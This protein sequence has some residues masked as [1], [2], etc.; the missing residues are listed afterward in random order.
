LR[1]KAVAWLAGFLACAASVLVVSAPRAA[2][3]SERLEFRNS[4]VSGSITDRKLHQPITLPAGSTLSATGE[5]DRQTGKGTLAANVLVP[6][7]SA[8]LR[9]FGVLPVTLAMTLT[10][11]GS[12]QGEL[13]PGETSGQE[14]LTLPLKLVV[15]VSSLSV[16]GMSIPTECTSTQP[17]AL[18]LAETLSREELLGQ[19]WHFSGTATLPS[20]GCEGPFPGRLLGFVFNY[21]ISGPENPYSVT[22]TPAV[23]STTS[24]TTT[25]AATTATSTTATTTQTTST[26]TSTT[27]TGGPEVVYVA[28]ADSGPVD[29]YRASSSGA[30]TPVVE[31]A[32]PQDPSTFWDPWGV[33]LDRAGDIY[34]QSFL[35]DATTFVFAPHSAPGAL[36]SRIFRV[37]GPDSR[38]IAVDQEG[39]EYVPSGE[40][41]SVIAVAA[42]G[43]AGAA[44]AGLYSVEPVRTFATG[45][46]IFSPW[47]DILTTSGHELLFASAKGEGNAVETFAGGPS[48]SA[49]PLRVL[50]GSATGLGTCSSPCDHVAVG[51]SGGNLYA[52]VSGGAAESHV[53]VFSSS[54]SGNS[55]P[56]RTI[57]GSA[58]GL[59]GKVITGIAASPATGELYVMVKAAEFEASGQIEVF[60]P[61]ASGNVAPLRTFTDAARAFTDAMGI[62]IGPE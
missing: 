25:T 45:E 13:A 42:P 7:F 46:G 36:P 60:A 54:A 59:D 27:G 49:T 39:Y 15:R 35:S 48:G 31:L 2:A 51:Y 44:G 37:Y 52:A 8:S 23:S 10:Q 29:G 43:A 18:G 11:V 62:A 61:G 12:A 26:S 1:L 38:A 3:S 16:L 6:A 17:L 4:V 40:S 47:P 14:T 41:G 19:P 20:F 50:S 21:F 55:V 34:V 58:T 9:L 30:V 24:T 28:N 32:N 53:S 33:A 56:L 5:L 22:V 57:A